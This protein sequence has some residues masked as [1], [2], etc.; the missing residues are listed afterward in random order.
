MP[1]SAPAASKSTAA[2]SASSGASTAAVESHRVQPGDTMASLAKNYY[3]NERHAKFL[4]ESNPAI[5]DPTRLAAGTIVRIPP[6]PPESSMTAKKGSANSP[7]DPA[8]ASADKRTYKVKQGD[9]FYAIAR[10]VLGDAKRWRELFDL[11]KALVS[12]DAT[13]LK[14]GQVIQLPST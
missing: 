2:Q 1:N 3:G 7:A 5:A 11:N 4:V 6:L 8:T 13:R 14:P 10:D 9:T 12:G